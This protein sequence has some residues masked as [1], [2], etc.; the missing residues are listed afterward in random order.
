MT[1]GDLYYNLVEKLLPGEKQLMETWVSTKPIMITHWD[2]DLYP[3]KPAPG[4]QELVLYGLL[5]GVLRQDSKVF[6]KEVDL[7]LNPKI[8]SAFEDDAVVGQFDSLLHTGRFKVLLPPLSTDFGDV[9]P[10][11]QPMTAVARERDRKKR[12][13]KT[14]IRRLTRADEVY[15]AKLYKILVGARATQFRKDFP[16]ENTF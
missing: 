14:R 3:A 12:P 9:D 5:C 10:N 15:C 8:R 7:L 11:V 6:I 16:A 2:P 1:G 4:I 13:Y